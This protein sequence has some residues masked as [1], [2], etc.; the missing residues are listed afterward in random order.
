MGKKIY[1]GN[2]PFTSTEDELRALFTRHGG[3]DS[4]A[5][6]TDRE[7]GRPRGFAFVEMADA[8]AAAD[9]IKALDGTQLG[10]RALRVNEAQDRR[11]GGG[12][13]RGFGGGG[14][15]FRGGRR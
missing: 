11:A 2:L 5:V 15:G 6:V 1:V 10:G 7:T 12:G 13:D 9:A 4:V 8:N 3:V 14:G